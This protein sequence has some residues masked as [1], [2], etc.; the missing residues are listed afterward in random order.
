MI[1]L[2]ESGAYLLHGREIIRE[3]EKQ[4]IFKQ[5]GKAG[6]RDEARKGTIAY[7]ILQAHNVSDDSGQFRLKADALVSDDLTWVGIVQTAKASGME[8]FSVPYVL[9]CCHNSLHAIGGTINADDHAFGLSACKKYGGIF[10]PPHVAVMHQ[11]MREQMAGCGKLI[12]GSDSHTRYGALGTMAMGEGGGEIVKQ[13]LSDTYDV[14]KPEVVAVYLTGKPRPGVGP[15][16]IALALIRAVYPIGFVKNKVLEFVGPA[17]TSMTADYRNGIDVMTTETTC[18]SSIWQ[19]DEETKKFLKI[20]GREKEYR[21]LKPADIAWYDKMIVMDLDQVKPMIALPFHPSNAF[22]IDE[23]HANAADI[24]REV[25]KRSEKFGDDAGGQLK[26]VDKL[27][28]GRMKINQAIIA[29]CAGGTYTNIMDAAHIL[30]RECKNPTEVPLSVYPASQPIYFN[31]M[32]QGVIGQLMRNGVTVKTAFCGPCIGACD[33]PANHELSIR[34]VTRNFANREGSQPA[35]GQMAAVALMDARSIAATV[36]NGGILTSAEEVAD[37]YQ[38]PEYQFDGEIYRSQIYS[39]FGA[40]NQREN[41]IYGPNI[42]D[43]PELEPLKD[44]LLLKVCATILDDVTTTDDLI[45]SGEISS[46]RS[47]PW[48]LAEFTL[49]SREPAYVART[50]EVQR[51][52]YAAGIKNASDLADIVETEA[53]A[54]MD[55]EKRKLKD[56]MR[57]IHGILNQELT[58]L[59]ELEIGSVIYA[60]RPGDGSAREQAA[61]CQRILG[62]LANISREYA[63]KRYRSN[64]INW[65]MLPFQLKENICFETGDYIYIPHVKQ[66]LRECRSVVPAYVLGENVQELSLYLAP[67]TE[68]ERQIVEAGGLINFNQK[69]MQSTKKLSKNYN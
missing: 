42:K 51:M 35:A 44:K 17:I 14:P 37:N 34:H 65:G 61:S 27:V 43:W 22:E 36:A 26:L 68:E 3:E 66:A 10:I 69:R 8:R 52:K 19:T 67:M 20:H 32:E 23:F 48:K 49:M 47:N 13:L 24:L 62:G 46:H 30:K 40:G 59:S 12:L 50:R 9:S 53:T 16:D 58:E 21:E 11:Y 6:N 60:V 2:Y 55:A 56:L 63:T 4:K 54:E 5:T 45:P 28:D 64:M 1:Q 38:V 41:L 25:E 18:W 33:I 57:K 7:P 15:Q 39:A 29:G 31:L